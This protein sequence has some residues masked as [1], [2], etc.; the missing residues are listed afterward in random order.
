[1]PFN[2]SQFGERALWREELRADFFAHS[3]P[4]PLCTSVGSISTWNGDG[5]QR[6]GSYP[7][8]A[9][10]LKPMSSAKERTENG[11]RQSPGVNLGEEDSEGFTI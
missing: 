3:W 2:D 8:R 5:G 4:L 6:P 10:S 7:Q 11:F 9:G 1:M